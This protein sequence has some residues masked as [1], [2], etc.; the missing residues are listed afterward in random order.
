MTAV[1]PEI[2]DLEVT[3]VDNQGRP[4][5]AYERCD[6]NGDRAWFYLGLI[7]INAS[8]IGWAVYQAW[9]ARNLSVEYSESKYIFKALQLTVIVIFV[10]TPLMILATEQGDANIL[11]FAISAIIF[12]FGC[13]T[14]CLIF[15]PKIKASKQKE[16]RRHHT[17]ISGFPGHAINSSNLDRRK[18]GIKILYDLS[19]EDMLS[20]IQTLESQ[21]QEVEGKLK[22]AATTNGDTK[23]ESKALLDDNDHHNVPIEII[24][25]RDELARGDCET[26]TLA[27]RS[28]SI[29]VGSMNLE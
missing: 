15:I 28:R 2:V 29:L 6:A 19:P 1:D 14:L 10:A 13:S 22:I 25:N 11:L 5:E 20:K 23:N 24:E 17:R 27:S 9:K 8:A 4:V 3:R 26:S 7:L 16:K 18:S 12:V 21:L